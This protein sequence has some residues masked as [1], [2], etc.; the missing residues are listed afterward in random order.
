MTASVVTL[1]R[2]PA[3]EGE[4][5]EEEDAR[6]QRRHRVEGRGGLNESAVVVRELCLSD[7]ADSAFVR[8][9]PPYDWDF[10]V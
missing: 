10:R 3:A 8:A 6:H 2:R 1:R 9:R 7:G 5:E 4:E